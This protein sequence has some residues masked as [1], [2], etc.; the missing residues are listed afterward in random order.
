[1]V[2]L[3]HVHAPVLADKAPSQDEAS[4]DRHSGHD[5]VGGEG[6]GVLRR[7]AAVVKVRRPDLCDFSVSTQRL[8]SLSER[9]SPLPSDEG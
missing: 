7:V 5:G 2:A 8:K 3:C 1:M 9:N 6:D 4:R